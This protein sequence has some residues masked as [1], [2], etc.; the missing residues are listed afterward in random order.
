MKLVKK[1]IFKN[2]TTVA[3]VT[4]KDGYFSITGA[5]YDKREISEYSDGMTAGGCIHYEITKKFPSLLPFVCLHLSDLNG[6][7]MHGIENSLYH[8]KNGF[9][10]K[11]LTEDQFILE[12][13]KYYRIPQKFFNDLQ[14]LQRDKIAYTLKF[15]ELGI[16]DLWK[17]QAAAGLKLLSEMIEAQN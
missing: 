2:I 1:N 15:Q 3:T 4:T 5:I 10:N 13:C 16:F 7:P 14:I 17:E 9:Q 6:V 12:W 8:L 11:E